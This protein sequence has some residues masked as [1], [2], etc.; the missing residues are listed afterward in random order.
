VIFQQ[1]G[2]PVLVTSG[3][4][5]VSLSNLVPT[6]I[7]GALVVADAVRIERL[8]GV[9]NPGRPGAT[10]TMQVLTM[11]AIGVGSTYHVDLVGTGPGA[12]VADAVFSP[13]YPLHIDGALLELSSTSFS[14]P[15]EPTGYLIMGV[16]DGTFEN[17]PN[18]GDTIDLVVG[19][20]RHTFSIIYDPSFVSLV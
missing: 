18:D 3:T 8:A 7:D 19:T 13:L 1:L 17:L 4:L 2:D 6:E 10:D 14:P 15:S 9:V 16:V 5:R 20:Q 11:D 12:N